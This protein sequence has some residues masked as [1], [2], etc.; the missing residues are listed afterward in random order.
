[1]QKHLQHLTS[2]WFRMVVE[3]M[4]CRMP[5]EPTS[6]VPGGIHGGMRGIL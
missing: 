6:L 5:V 1:M 2:Q 4:T 3:L